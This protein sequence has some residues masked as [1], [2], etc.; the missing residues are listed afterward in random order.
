MILIIWKERG[1]L[2][3]KKCWFLNYCFIHAVIVFRAPNSEQ[4]KSNTLRIK[5]F[6]FVLFAAN[7][8]SLGIYQKSESKQFKSCNST[9]IRY[10]R[11]PEAEKKKLVAGRLA[12]EK[13]LLSP[14]GS[15]LKTLAKQVNSAYLKN[16]N[17]T[18]KKAR[19]I[20]TGKTNCTPVFPSFVYTLMHVCV[21][22]VKA[23]ESV[24]RMTLQNHKHGDHYSVDFTIVLFPVQ[25]INL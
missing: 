2:A 15:D 7:P 21:Q 14:G 22:W 23:F 17:M 10:G 11:M 12:G 8:C 5:A 4:V 13:S 20:L 6:L 24:L 3:G 9:A 16:L 25:N 18:K 19:S 1:K